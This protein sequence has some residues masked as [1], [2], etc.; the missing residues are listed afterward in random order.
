MI[1]LDTHALLWFATDD[2]KLGS[3]A[4]RAAD[5]ALRKDEV[6]VSAF[7]FWELA[8]LHGKGRIAVDGTIGAFRV[9][10]LAHGIVEVPVDGAVAIGAASL[11]DFHGDPADRVIVASALARGATLVTADELILGWRGALKR[12]DART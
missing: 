2:A 6:L 8:M 11:D 12:L 9:D 3:R 1:L 7:S 10:A 5:A 4:D